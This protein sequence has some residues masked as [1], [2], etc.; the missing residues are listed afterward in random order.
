MDPPQ[1]SQLAFRPRD[2]YLILVT[3]ISLHA[4]QHLV[5]SILLSL[6]DP[7]STTTQ[8]PRV[9]QQD[10][11]EGSGSWLVA[12]SVL[13]HPLALIVHT[14][15]A[16]TAAIYILLCSDVNCTA[17]PSSET[18]VECRPSRSH[19]S[20]N[21]PPSQFVVTLKWIA[22]RQKPLA[23]CALLVLDA[24]SITVW[25]LGIVSTAR[26]NEFLAA[27]SGLC[28]ATLATIYASLIIP[29]RLIHAE[30]STA[31]LLSFIASVTDVSTSDNDARALGSGTSSLT[32]PSATSPPSQVLDSYDSTFLPQVFVSHADTS[33]PPAP[34]TL[35][36]PMM[37]S[38][39][40][41]PLIRRA[42]WKI[43]SAILVCVAA[44]CAYARG[45]VVTV[46]AKLTAGVIVSH[47]VAE[48][49]R[50]VTDPRTVGVI[51][52]AQRQGRRPSL[53]ASSHRARPGGGAAPATKATAQ[54]LI[55]KS[56]A[57]SQSSELY[58]AWAGSAG[59]DLSTVVGSVRP[60][61]TQIIATSNE[62]VDLH[63][64]LHT[65]LAPGGAA[66]PERPTA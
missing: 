4:G 59:E 28:A 5:K 41:S 47:V 48:C 64:A 24:I 45:W 9:R 2:L 3:F 33:T 11:H 46:D 26:A 54:G 61:A 32:V 25:V 8:K 37:P 6:S 65:S 39:S 56:A 23:R 30:S 43:G 10:D 66:A 44:A 57:L 34:G 13:V 63:T 16:F 40:T 12:M 17:R 60:S 18:R 20:I 38:V 51:R 50:F 55:R 22:A 53:S 27:A 36:R 29:L 58:R 14:T 21:A 42:A 19:D 7:T 52:L 1:T 49:A 62:E 35:V 15:A 31:R